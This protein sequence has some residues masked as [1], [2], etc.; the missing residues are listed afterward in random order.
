MNE[1]AVQPFTVEKIGVHLKSVVFQLSKYFWNFHNHC[2]N[3]NSFKA[4]EKSFKKIV[5]WIKRAVFVIP[6]IRICQINF[7]ILLS[8]HE[9]LM[10]IEWNLCEL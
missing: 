5:I 10:K 9:Y 6:R 4:L 8:T 7:I 2:S 1:K 3:I